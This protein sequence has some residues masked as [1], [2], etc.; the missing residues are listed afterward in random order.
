VDDKEI[1]INIIILEDVTEEK[2]SLIDAY[3]DILETCKNKKE[4]RAA[5]KMIVEESCEINTKEIF[6]RLVQHLAEM[7]SKD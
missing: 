7:I 2:E 5:I 3:L 4:K 6:T 1:P